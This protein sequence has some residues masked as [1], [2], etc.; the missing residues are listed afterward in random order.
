MAGGKTGHRLHPS[1]QWPGSELSSTYTLHSKWRWHTP[2]SSWRGVGIAFG[3]PSPKLWSVGDKPCASAKASAARGWRPKGVR[4]VKEKRAN[5]N[6]L[7]PKAKMEKEYKSYFLKTLL[8]LL[9]KKK[10]T[11]SDAPAL[12]KTIEGL[13]KIRWNVH[14]NAPFGGPAQILEY[15]GRYT[16]NL[17]RTCFGKTAITAHRITAITGNDIKF[18]YKDY[19]DGKKQKQ[20][21]LS[22]QEFARRFEQ[23]YLSRTYSGYCQN[24][25]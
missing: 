14:A 16:H 4:W 17:S 15:L 22:H 13:R 1:Y 5:G 7:F 6:Y 24:G 21:T 3:A 11:I 2:L 18:T 19:A 23:H 12:E 8:K 25:L 20:M 9:D 10:L